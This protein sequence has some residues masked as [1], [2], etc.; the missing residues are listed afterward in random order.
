VA[1][2]RV[3]TRMGLYLVTPLPYNA[4]F[5]MTND[6]RQMLDTL[7]RKQPSVLQ[8]NLAEERERL[9]RRRRHSF[10]VPLP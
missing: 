2:S 5:S 6:L 8:W 7:Q 10:D 3:K 9:E 4:D 1:L